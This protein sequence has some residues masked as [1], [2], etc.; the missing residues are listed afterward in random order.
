[1]DGIRWKLKDLTM[2]LTT[3]RDFNR[4]PLYF[5]NFNFG[6]QIYINAYHVSNG[7]VHF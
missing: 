5:F 4:F 2:T 6:S 7:Y 1:M 3:H